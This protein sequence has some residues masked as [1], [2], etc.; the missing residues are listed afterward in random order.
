MIPKFVYFPDKD[1]ISTISWYKNSENIGFEIIE[2]NLS[3]TFLYRLKLGLCENFNIGNY[4]N[5]KTIDDFVNLV[6]TRSY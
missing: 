1:H 2:V 6:E 4:D 5:Q 3:L